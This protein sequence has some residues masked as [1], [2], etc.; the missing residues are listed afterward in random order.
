MTNLVIFL[1]GVVAGAFLMGLL[2]AYIFFDVQK[3]WD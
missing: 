2:V 1:A 3:G